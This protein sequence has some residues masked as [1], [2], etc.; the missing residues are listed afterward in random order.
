MV[1]AFSE[2]LRESVIG[3]MQAEPPMTVAELAEESGCSMHQLYRFVDGEWM[4]KENLDKLTA[5]L[6]I[7]VRWE[8]NSV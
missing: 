3:F 4:G 8:D 6:G 7:V 2:E 1:M 5:Y